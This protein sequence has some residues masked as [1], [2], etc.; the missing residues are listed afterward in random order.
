MNDDTHANPSPDCGVPTCSAYI[1]DV[2]T[3]DVCT[4]GVSSSLTNYPSV[5]D[6]HVI[7][8]DSSS[9]CSSMNN[10]NN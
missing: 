3:N 1:Q 2:T 7:Y 8:S 10:Y 5:S 9:T 6:Q 4:N